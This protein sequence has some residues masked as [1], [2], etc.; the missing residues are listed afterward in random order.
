GVGNLL[1]KFK[2][3]KL[4]RP[5]RARG[6]AVIIAVSFIVAAFVGNVRLNIDSFYTFIN[7]LIPAL[8]FVV[9]MLNRSF[10]IKLLIDILDYLYNPLRK[11]VI[12]SNRY[13]Q[14][15]NQVIT[16]QEFVFFTKGDDVA[17]LNK[18]MQYVQENETTTK[19]KIV[20]VKLHN[21][22]NEMLIKDIEVLDRAYPE[23]HIE[24][25]EMEGV[26]GPTLIDELSKKWMIPKNFM[27]IA[28][29]SDRFSYRVSDLGGVRL[30]M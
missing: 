20:N 30:I 10:L 14:K 21:T 28:S 6:I 16:E 12:N 1:L 3:K 19:L 5:E 26:F 8:A 2:R 7:Y 29:P 4:P 24:F 22:S 25:I 18:V 27:F 17:I 13:L 11:F 9:I 15:L 23:I